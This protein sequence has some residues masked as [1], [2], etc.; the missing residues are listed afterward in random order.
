MNSPPTPAIELISVNGRMWSARVYKD[1][2]EYNTQYGRFQYWHSLY[3]V[4]AQIPTYFD[5]S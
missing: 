5:K 4:E 2:I 1:R 3:G